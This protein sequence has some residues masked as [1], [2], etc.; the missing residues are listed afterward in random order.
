M[1]Q[2]QCVDIAWRH[3]SVQEMSSG[4]HEDVSSGNAYLGNKSTVVQIAASKQH[5]E[6]GEVTMQDV[7]AVQVGHAGGHLPGSGQDANQVRQP[8]YGRSVGTEPTSVNAI[9]QMQA[10]LIQG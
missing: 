1:V 6:A 2:A 8:I 10:D 5:I 4:G 3:E 7:Q 9:L